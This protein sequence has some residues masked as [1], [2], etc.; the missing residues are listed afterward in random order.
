MYL[1]MT[2]NVIPGG[3]PISDK[4]LPLVSSSIKTQHQQRIE[5][6]MEKAGQDLPSTPSVPDDKIRVLRARLIMEEAFE[7][8]EAMGV[9]AF[10]QCSDGA[11]DVEFK[12]LAFKT[13]QKSEELDLPHIAKELADI[14]VVNIGTMSA[15]GISDNEVLQAVDENNL[16]KFGPGGFRDSNGKWRKPP[17]HP[18]PDIKAILESQGMTNTEG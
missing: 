11:L 14:S 4:V 16:A 1:A 12:D 7:A 6:M 2:E 18:D 8:L 9:A 17:N 13:F 10:T 15:F 5:Q 3:I